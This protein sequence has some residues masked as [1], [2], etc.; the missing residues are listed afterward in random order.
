M[1]VNLTDAQ[2]KLLDDKNFAHLATV[3]ESGAPQVTPVWIEYDGTH[4]RFNT[5]EKRAK[6]KHMKKNPRVALSVAN[7]EN[8]YHYIEIRGTVVET[9]TEGADEMIDRLAKKYLGQDK[10]PFNKPGD[11][12][13]IVKILPDKV[14]GIGGE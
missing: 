5:E 7:A 6:V 10:Y 12:R 8:P 2:R 14:L 3:D 11:V 1:P 13:L 9:T 4:V